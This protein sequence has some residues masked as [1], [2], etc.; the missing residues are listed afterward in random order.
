[1]RVGVCRL[2]QQQE[3]ERKLVEKLHAVE[4]AQRRRQADRSEA[5]ERRK[6]EEAAREAEATGDYP[7]RR[8]AEQPQGPGAGGYHQSSMFLWLFA[9]CHACYIFI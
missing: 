3:Q 1:M 6:M 5:E 8:A 9:C 4:E 2:A 7:A